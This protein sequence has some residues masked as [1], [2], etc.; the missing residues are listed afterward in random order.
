MLAMASGSPATSASAASAASAQRSAGSVAEKDR[1]WDMERRF[2]AQP[3]PFRGK[4]IFFGGLGDD[5]VGRLA[6]SVTGARLDTDQVRPVAGVGV[7]ERG[8]IFEAV[9]RHDAV[10]GVGGRHQHR[11]IGRAVPDVVIGRIGQ[12]VAK[13]GLLRRMRSEEHTS[14]LQ[15]LMRI[16]YAVFC[17]KKK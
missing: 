1:A 4:G 14:E 13:I 8:G 10:V 11:R 5:L 7:L 9:P 16:S 6:R 12:K 2:D 15:S 17:L 3:G